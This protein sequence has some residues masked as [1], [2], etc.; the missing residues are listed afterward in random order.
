MALKLYRKPI[1][2]FGASDGPDVL[3]TYG[4]G[5][6]EAAVTAMSGSIYLDKDGT[7]WVKESGSGNTGWAEV[8]SG[9]SS[10]LVSLNGLTADTQTFVTG[11]TGTDFGISSTSSTHTFNLPTASASNRGL[12]SS[13]DWST[14]NGKVSSSVTT[15]SSLSSIGT[16]TSGTWNGTVVAG[17][18]GGTGVAN[19]GLTITLA[20][21]FATSG[22]N[23][24]TLTTSGSTNVTLP[25]SGTLAALGGTNSWSGQQTFQTGNCRIG[26]S[27]AGVGIFVFTGATSRNITLPSSAASTLAAINIAQTWTAAQ[28]FTTG[29]TTISTESVTTSTIA[30]LTVTTSCVIAGLEYLEITLI[31]ADQTGLLITSAASQVNDFLVCYNAD[32]T[33]DV[34]AVSPTGDCIVKRAG[35]GLRIAEGSNAKM[36]TVTLVGGAATVSNSSVTADSRIYL[37]AQNSSGT[38]GSLWVSARTAGTSFNISSTNILDTRTVAWMIVEPA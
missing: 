13:T 19:T 10:G 33:A 7:L 2:F 35:S 30:D 18:Y 5:T 24:L 38:A 37:T 34:F 36:G 11:T 1:Q 29:T 28:T 14:F 8:G 21:N 15:L 32:L 12:L 27:G 16:I 17:Q 4:T 25:T 22:A 20:G 6:P 23:S 31:D 3:I 26:G 9:S